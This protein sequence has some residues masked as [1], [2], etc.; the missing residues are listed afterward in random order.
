MMRDNSFEVSPDAA[1]NFAGVGGG[2]DGFFMR[3]LRRELES[4]SSSLVHQG[5]ADMDVRERANAPDG[6]L[7][8]TCHVETTLGEMLRVS[9][10]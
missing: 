4:L 8:P 1:G 5:R 3:D 10:D 2:A 9:Y 6:R 7:S